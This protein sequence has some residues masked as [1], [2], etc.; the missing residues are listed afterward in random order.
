MFLSLAKG[1]EGLKALL[2]ENMTEKN[3]EDNKDDQLEQLQTEMAEMR[4]QMIGHMELI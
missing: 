3:P 4:T 1:R 2:V